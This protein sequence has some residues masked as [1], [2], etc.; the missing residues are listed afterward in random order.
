LNLRPPGYEPGELPDCSTPRRDGK[1]SIGFVP[2]WTWTALVVFSVVVA[3][4][5]AVTTAALIQLRRLASTGEEL[6]RSLDELN[7]K[8]EALQT[9]LE[10][11]EERS[12]AVERKLARL[13]ESYERL[14][15]LLWALGDVRRTISHVTDAVTLRK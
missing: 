2:W 8:A 12:E 10:Q 4:G 3:A 1:D 13:D 14:S 7:A 9:R 5:A 15:V 11:A 6:A